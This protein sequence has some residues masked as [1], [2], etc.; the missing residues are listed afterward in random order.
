MEMTILFNFYFVA[1]FDSLFLSFMIEIFIK[2]IDQN[3]IDCAM[4]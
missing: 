2:S 4:K 1:I 3:L